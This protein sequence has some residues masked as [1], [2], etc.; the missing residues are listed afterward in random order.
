MGDLWL[1]NLFFLGGGGLWEGGGKV[2]NAYGTEFLLHN[3]YVRRPRSAHV[4][5][6]RESISP[7]WS[8]ED[9]VYT[10]WECLRVRHKW[11]SLIICWRKRG[12]FL[13]STFCLFLFYVWS[14]VR[15]T[16][17]SYKRSEHYK[18]AD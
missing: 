3:K 12:L 6:K 11:L 4:D 5:S 7:I 16:K 8:R 18:L 14:N 17:G 13:S 10:L 1:S 15:P 9:G 2:R